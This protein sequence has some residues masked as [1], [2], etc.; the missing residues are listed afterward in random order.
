MTKIST[1]LLASLLATGAAFAGGT[2]TVT[3]AVSKMDCAACPLT[4]R[5]ALQK[6]PGV[7]TAKVDFKTR[8]AVVA[9]D[10]NQTSP[11]ALM[12]ATATAGYPSAVTQVQ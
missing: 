11:A 2:N 6:V 10:P 8:L 12:K 9:F 5:A 7:S 4:V 3:L 1:L